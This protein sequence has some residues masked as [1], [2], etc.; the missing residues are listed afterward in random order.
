MK[1]LQPQT[2]DRVVI[3]DQKQQEK[4]LKLI[5]S[6]K[7][8]KGLCLFEMDIDTGMISKAE[9]K[10]VISTLTGAVHKQLVMKPKHLYC[11][12]LNFRNADRKF[13]KMISK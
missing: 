12:A 5:G 1:E 2:E 4:K 6:I 8:Q 3:T 7:P 11:V 10:S 13:V 9:F